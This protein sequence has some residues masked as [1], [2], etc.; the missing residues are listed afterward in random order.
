MTNATTT[1][2]VLPTSPLRLCAALLLVPLVLLA[3]GCDSNDSS[4]DNGTEDPSTIG[5]SADVT[6]TITNQ[7]TSAW[8]V[9]DVQ[10]ASGVAQTGTD[11]PTLTLKVGTRYRIDNNGGSNHPFALQNAN[12]EYLLRQESG[13]AGSF[14]DDSDVNYQESTDRVAFTYT[15]SLADATETY[16]C[17]V[18]PSMEGTVQIDGERSSTVPDQI[19]Y[20]LAAQ[21]NDGAAPNGIGGTVTFWRAGPDS[22]LVT[23]D[24][25][26][27]ATVNSVSHPAHI[28]SGS[29]SEG[30]KIAIYLS[31]VNGS[32]PTGTSARKIG[33]P[34]EDLARFDG[35]VN[36]HESPAKLGNVVAQG[37]IG[38]NAEGTDGSGLSL[39]DNPRSTTYPLAA[40]STDGS[41]LSE[42]V[43]GTVRVEEL[44]GS[45]TLVTY[46]LDTNGSVE[47]ANGSSVDVAQIAHIHENT[48]SA[49]GSIVSGPFS[50]YLGSIAPTDS[51][52]RSS[53]ILNASYD[54]LTS[55][56][57]HVNV[58]QSNANAQYVFAQ[59]NIG[60]SAGTSGSSA[61]V[62]ITIDN[63]GASAWKVT[64][65]QGASGVAQTGTENPT[66]TLEVGT[67]YRIDNNGG[68]GAHPF[69]LQNA[70]DEYLLRQESD[71]SGSLEDD[72]DINYQEDA[73]GVTF[74]YTQS[75]D[76]ATETYRCTLHP[77]MEGTVET[78]SGGSGY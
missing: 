64:D 58:H 66:L 24:L 8:E 11:N 12:G 17:T 48:V 22:S 76:N 55:Y 59:G 19:T 77:S 20:D 23:L 4:M 75:L 78:D 65:V 33:R 39:V 71:K 28:H 13:R 57:G 56:K 26:E 40:D 36:V 30:G 44:T 1:T 34:I 29:A 5:A 38:A 51:A 18:H 63:Q 16:I 60:A 41:V 25:D 3:T 54:E 45:K 42:G 61:D 67:R 32:S 7:G 27:D 53:R 74:T 68:R 14:E 21:S 50:G 6:I 2:N 62:T 69:A 37:N 9:T 15:Q 49:G 73:D 31:A 46:A 70:S 10:G 72:A 35:H 47:N 52:A 43:T